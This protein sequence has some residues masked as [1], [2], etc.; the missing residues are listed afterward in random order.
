M[1]K[2]IVV[3]MAVLM[4]VSFTSCNQD[5][6]D[7]LE[8]KVKE[9]EAEIA[10]KNAEDETYNKFVEDFLSVMVVKYAYKNLLIK[11]SNTEDKNTINLTGDEY[12]HD[13]ERIPNFTGD[14]LARY[15]LQ[16]KVLL[17]TPDCY[18][19][20]Y[21]KNSTGTVTL[22]EACTDENIN[23]NMDNN[24]VTYSYNVSEDSEEE[25]LELGINGSLIY[26]KNSESSSGA[27]GVYTFTVS[28]KGTIDGEKIDL[29]CTLT[30]DD[31]SGL[32]FTSAESNGNKISTDRLNALE[33][34]MGGLSILFGAS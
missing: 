16:E 33:N 29:S 5:K 27:A 25:T 22:V 28:F 24:K 23:C 34:G 12:D 32:K 4:L 18:N 17:K 30:Q 6:I 7:E 26:K 20:P 19:K 8:K 13:E 15:W 11:G 9:Q 1:R 10:K 3:L 31:V 21:F 2:L 14:D